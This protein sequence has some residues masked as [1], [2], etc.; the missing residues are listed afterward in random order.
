MLASVP[1]LLRTYY[2]NLTWEGSSN[3]ENAV[4]LTFDDG[5][6]PEVTPWV[7]DLLKEY[8]IK[9]TFF[10]IGDNVR[11]YPDIF[12]RIVSEGHATGNHTF[13]HIKGWGSSDLEY[14]KNIELAR[15]LIDSKLFRPPYGR[16]KKSQIEL[17]RKDYQIIMWSVLSGDYNRRRS[18]SQCFLNVKRNLKS[19][20][21]IVF[22]DSLKAE[23]NMKYALKKTLELIKER[24]LNASLFS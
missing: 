20:S 5:P 1:K 15:E 11:K 14:L 12:E 19:G 8:D 16:I 10:C 18:P 23:R 13:N 7:L 6:I 9:A 2:P 3:I 4:Y 22:H 24:G 17:I 21:I